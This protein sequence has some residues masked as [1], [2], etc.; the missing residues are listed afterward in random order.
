MIEKINNTEATTTKVGSIYN[1]ATTSDYLLV[2]DGRWWN[3]TS[4]M[5]IDN[6]GYVGIGTTTPSSKTE[7]WGGEIRVIN[8]STTSCS[9]AIAGSIFF[10][11]TDRLFWKCN[12]TSWSTF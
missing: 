7:I 3:S 10:N 1:T 6:T 9:A 4:S 5:I 11:G 8:N 12:G 2:A